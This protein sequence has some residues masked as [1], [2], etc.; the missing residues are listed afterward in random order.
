MEPI[1][2]IILFADGGNLEGA[3]ITTVDDFLRV[4]DALEVSDVHRINTLNV[5]ERIVLGGGASGIFHVERIN[6]LP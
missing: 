1:K 2:A 5:G 6:D 4:N 3:S